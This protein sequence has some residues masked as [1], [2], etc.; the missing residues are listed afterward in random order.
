MQKIGKI[1]FEMNS[2]V[3]FRA[4]RERLRIRVLEREES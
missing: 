1:A 3:G 2:G 4:N